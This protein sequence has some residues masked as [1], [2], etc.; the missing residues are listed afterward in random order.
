MPEAK[1]KWS[2]SPKAVKWQKE[3]HKH[4]MELAIINA[5]GKDPELKYFVGVAGGAGV[6]FITALFNSAQGSQEQ[7]TAPVT[8]EGA[9][10]GWLA[11][12][13]GPLGAAIPGSPQRK[14]FDE[15]MVWLDKMNPWGTHGN[16][17]SLAGAVN[18][19]IGM[20]GLSFAGFCAAVL[21]LKAIFGEKGLGEMLSQLGGSGGAMGLVA[22]GL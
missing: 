6:A 14:A 18:A 8:P 10:A 3:K 11:I 4:E 9:F 15:A 7:P 21:L 16:P 2:P 20:A 5:F 1:K 22:G 19:G 12:S 17:P 13:L